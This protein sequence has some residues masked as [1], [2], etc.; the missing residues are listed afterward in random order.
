MFYALITIR[1][2][3][4]YDLPVMRAGVDEGVDAAFRAVGEFHC[5]SSQS[6]GTGKRVIVPIDAYA[7]HLFR[8]LSEFIA[9][10]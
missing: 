1:A 3:L 6:A 7:Q 4:A 10:F 8:M 5:I 9:V 2:Q